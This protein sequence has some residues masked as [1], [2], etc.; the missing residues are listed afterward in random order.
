M[1]ALHLRPETA[2]KLQG[3]A[4]MPAA[5]LGATRGNPDLPAVQSAR[6]VMHGDI[7]LSGAG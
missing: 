7:L 6:P 4:G 2:M 5:L 3:D 1:F